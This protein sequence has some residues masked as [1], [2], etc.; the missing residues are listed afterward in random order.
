MSSAYSKVAHSVNK[1][2]LTVMH[3]TALNS[4]LIRSKTK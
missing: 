1:N 3:I 2:E 4:F